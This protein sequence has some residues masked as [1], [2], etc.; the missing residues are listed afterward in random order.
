M[1]RKVK[2]TCTDVL[3]CLGRNGFYVITDYAKSL[4]AVYRDELVDVA[5]RLKMLIT[6]ALRPLLVISIAHAFKRG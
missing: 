5:R 3:S 4:K 2:L 6:I 1:C